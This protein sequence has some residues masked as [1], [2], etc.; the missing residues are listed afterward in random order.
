M[1]C[2]YLFIRCG[3]CAVEQSRGKIQC[4]EEFP[5]QNIDAT[6]NNAQIVS[7]HKYYDVH[8][9]ASL[10]LS[11]LNKHYIQHLLACTV[12]KYNSINE[13][14][15]AYPF[16][17]RVQYIFAVSYGTHMNPVLLSF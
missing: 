11:L 15:V 14:I 3:R 12:N 16:V 8:L 1:I 10:L 5:K 7:I 17:S 13:K 4:I 2:C 9:N 6:E